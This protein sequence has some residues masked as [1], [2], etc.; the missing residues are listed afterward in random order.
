M[1]LLSVIT[2]S[3]NDFVG[4]RR[5]C[6]SLEEQIH[7]DFEWVVI[8]G[9]S[10]IDVVKWLNSN[11]RVNKY[12]SE[13]DRGIYDA[14]RKGLILASGRYVI[15]LNSGDVFC[16]S[17]AVSVILKNISRM[18]NVAVFFYAT[19]VS[20]PHG[21]FIRKPRSLASAVYSVPAIQQSTVYKRSVLRKVDWPTEYRICG[22]Y[23]IAV[24]LYKKNVEWHSSPYTLSDFALGGV[25]TSRFILLARE[26]FQIQSR[27][28]VCSP[29]L[30]LLF[31]ARRLLIGLLVYCFNFKIVFF[32]NQRPSS[33]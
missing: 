23:A 30:R 31:F 28:S 24:Q 25:S 2:I 26:A 4:L 17:D 15:F 20:A 7:Q 10:G 21:S 9:G 12:I 5:T 33:S 14:M 22:D 18:P 1:S 32:Y 27:Y 29:M 3:F 8:D 19:K 11:Q 16:S 13:P 6:A